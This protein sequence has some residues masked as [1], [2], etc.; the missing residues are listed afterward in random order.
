MKTDSQ[1][2]IELEYRFLIP[3]ERIMVIP[4]HEVANFVLNNSTV[5]VFQDFLF[6]RTGTPL[7]DDNV[8][9]RLRKR[10][11]TDIEFTY[12]KF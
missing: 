6:E 5:V 3:R 12:K 4:P 8:G 10:D 7:K 1:K 9:F 11:D 2:K